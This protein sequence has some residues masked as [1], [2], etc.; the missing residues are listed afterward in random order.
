MKDDHLKYEHVEKN[1]V[2]EGVWETF[3]ILDDV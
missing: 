2:S 3:K 1:G